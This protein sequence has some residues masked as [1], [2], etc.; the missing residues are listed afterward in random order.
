MLSEDDFEFFESIGTGA[1]GEVFLARS[2]S[3]GEQYAVKVIDLEA[4]ETEL[5]DI[6][7]E[8]RFL[9]ECRSEYC[10]KYIGSFLKEDKLHIVMEYMGGGSVADQIKIGVLKEDHIAIIARQVLN[11]LN[12]L[13]SDGKIHRDIKAANILLGNDGAVKLADF[14][15][16]GS[17][18]GVTKRYTVVGTPYW[19]APEVITE[20]GT[21]QKADIWSLGITCIE[22]AKGMPP[23]ADVNPMI[24]LVKIPRSEAPK[25]DGP[26]F[27]DLFKDFVAKCLTKDPSKRL[28]AAELLNHP[29]IKGAQATEELQELIERAEAYKAKHPKSPGKKNGVFA[30]KYGKKNRNSVDPS[31]TIEAF[32]FDSVRVTK[33][34]LSASKEELPKEIKEADEPKS[35]SRPESRNES[36]P[37]SRNEPRTPE[38]RETRP[39]S[40]GDT[41]QEGMTRQKSREKDDDGPRSRRPSKAREPEKNIKDKEKPKDEKPKAS[42]V[43]VLKRLYNEED[44]QDAS[45]NS[46]LEQID[47]AFNQLE[48]HHVGV[49]PVVVD[50]LQQIPLAEFKAKQ[51]ANATAAAIATNATL[52]AVNSVTTVTN[53]LSRWEKTQLPK[54]EFAKY[55]FYLHK[56]QNTDKTKEGAS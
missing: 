45:F 49:L 37:E 6:Q 32:D 22:M 31:T 23:W 48:K 43:P 21:D 3:S 17:L 33:P 36:R 15:V 28:G 18:I 56:I 50:I 11:G 1:F 35:D 2:Y 20:A 13:H 7:R 29:Y 42:I 14:G 46:L 30:K 12:F 5:E 16:S 4:T 24:A 47:S 26:N 10:V 52:N 19:M 40:R 44:S 41:R 54:D 34:S 25:L 53:L 8:I 9:T 39:D 51:K 38:S 55:H 27:S